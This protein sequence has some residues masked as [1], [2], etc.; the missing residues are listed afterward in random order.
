MFILFFILQT[1]LE[2]KM[3]NGPSSYN[4]ETTST[5]TETKIVKMLNKKGKNR[6][7]Q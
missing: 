2:W 4:N 1:T 3:R 6:E 5:T 7:K